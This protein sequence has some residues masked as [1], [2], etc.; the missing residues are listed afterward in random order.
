MNK[1]ILCFA[2]TSDWECQSLFLV[3]LKLCSW[4]SVICGI[5]IWQLILGHI[6]TTCE[7]HMIIILNL[8]I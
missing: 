8:G 5:L 1:V 6:Y 2:F 7:T 4:L 3:S